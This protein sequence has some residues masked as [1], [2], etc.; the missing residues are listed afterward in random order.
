MYIISLRIRILQARYLSGK[1]SGQAPR[2]ADQNRISQNFSDRKLDFDAY[3]S[4]SLAGTV[5]FFALF[6][7]NTS[8]KT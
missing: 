7:S 2:V 4:G 5:H 3:V 8:F 6:L 1:M